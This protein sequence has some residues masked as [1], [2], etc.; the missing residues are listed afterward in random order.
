MN[1]PIAG[2]MEVIE[3]LDVFAQI[4]EVDSSGEGAAL[5]V[6]DNPLFRDQ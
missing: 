5:T 3:V 2:V 6:Y 4:L 1:D